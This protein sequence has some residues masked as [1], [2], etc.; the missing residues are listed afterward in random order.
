MK[1]V[2]SIDMLIS[3]KC[4]QFSWHLKNGFLLKTSI[5]NLQGLCRRLGWNSTAILVPSNKERHRKARSQKWRE[6]ELGKVSFRGRTKDSLH[7]RSQSG[8]ERQRNNPSLRS[9][10]PYSLS[11]ARLPIGWTQSAATGRG[12][13]WC[14]CHGASPED[15]RSQAG[16]RSEKR[17]MTVF[18]HSM[19]RGYWVYRWVW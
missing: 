5:W 8:E 11:L 19:R 10:P 15:G 3:Q 1:P 6:C 17:I 16:K 2:A 13:P 9:L 14:L 4:M 7:G 18:S 12:A